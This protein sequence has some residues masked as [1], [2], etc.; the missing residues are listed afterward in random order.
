MSLVE[1]LHEELQ[2]LIFDNRTVFLFREID[3]ESSEQ[4]CRELLRLSTT[5]RKITLVMNCEGGS[6]FSGFSVV[7]MIEYCNRRGAM[8]HAVVLGQCASMAVAVL[9]A[10]HKRLVSPRSHVMLHSASVF[11]E[12]YL[13]LAEDSLQFARRDWL[14]Y[15]EL[16]CER[17][18]Y[19][20]KQLEKRLVGRELYLTAEEAIEVGLADGTL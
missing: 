20:P 15:L 16:L 18:V 8:V 10:A 5:R 7:D 17:S 13:S 19:T 2:Q 9:Q 11:K 14:R 1:R 4:V 6:I 3:Q 12:D